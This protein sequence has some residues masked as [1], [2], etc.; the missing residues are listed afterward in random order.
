MARKKRRKRLDKKHS[1]KGIISVIIG[2]ISLIVLIILFY[3]SALV[4]GDGDILLGLIG[5]ILLIASIVGA[6]LGYQGYK[7]KDIEYY[8]PITGLIL[9]SLTFLL[10]FV[11]YVMGL[12]L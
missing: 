5:L 9:N 1:L 3:V 7:E 4:D 8:L 10:L 6:S 2:I 12:L 11:L